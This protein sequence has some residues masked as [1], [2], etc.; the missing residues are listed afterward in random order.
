MYKKK[1]TVIVFAGIALLFVMIISGI[2]FYYYWMEVQYRRYFDITLNELEQMTSK[3]QL[4]IN[5]KK[6]EWIVKKKQFDDLSLTIYHD[7]PYTGGDYDAGL[8]YRDV[9]QLINDI[10]D[11]FYGEIDYEKYEEYYGS[12]YKYIYYVNVDKQ[13]L[14]QHS[15]ELKKLNYKAIS[16]VSSSNLLRADVYYVFKYKDKPLLE[17]AMWGMENDA[18]RFNTDMDNWTIFINNVEV[19]NR[20]VFYDIIL[21]FMT[22][23][24]AE[25]FVA[26]SEHCKK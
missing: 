17:V 11:V 8:Y 4:E 6:Y 21:P 7:W 2:M 26:V 22:E 18:D 16:Y 25:Y 13:N 23:E 24:S 20:K 1:K 3:D 10:N 14:L 5:I 12:T 9:G 15:K 19:E